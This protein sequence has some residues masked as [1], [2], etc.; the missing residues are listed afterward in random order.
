MKK[1]LEKFRKP[2]YS[3]KEIL[4]PHQNQKKVTNHEIKILA[5]DGNFDQIKFI[6]SKSLKFLNPAQVQNLKYLNAQNLKKPVPLQNT[7]IVQVY[8]NEKY[9]END[10]LEKIIFFIKTPKIIITEIFKIFYGLITDEKY[11]DEI[12]W[13]PVTNEMREKNFHYD[14]KKLFWPPTERI[15][16]YYQKFAD[17]VKNIVK[18]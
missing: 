14:G 13:M 16:Y 12:Y 5:P 17:C 1:F 8:F 7:K 2:K 11:D 9:I 3:E 6:F 4:Q 10:I 18:K 15:K